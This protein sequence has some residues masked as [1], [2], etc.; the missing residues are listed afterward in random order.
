MTLNAA[1]ALWVKPVA[2]WVNI[3]SDVVDNYNF[4]AGL[5][6]SGATD[7]VARTGQLS[8]VLDNSSS[9]YTPGAVS[10]LSG[11]KSGIPAKLVVTYDGETFIRFY[12]QI[13]SINISAGIY[14]ERTV[15]VT[16]VD[17]MDN[18][19]K[20][21]VSGVNITADQ[22]ADQVITTIKSGMPVKPISSDLDTGINTF[23]QSFDTVTT[24]T[25]ALSEFNKIANSEFGYVYLKK[26]AAHGETLVFD[27]NQAR[28]GMRQLDVLPMGSSE[29]ANLLAEDST[30]LLAEDGEAL[31]VNTPRS[32]IF[33]DGMFS[34]LKVTYGKGLVNRF[35]VKVEPKKEDTTPQILF[36]LQKR[37]KL[38]SGI[39]THVTGAFSDP[40]GGKPITGKN[41]I[42]PVGTTDYT[43]YTNWDGTGSNITGDLTIVATYSA[44]SVTYDLT[45]GNTATGYVWVQA[46]G[47]GVYPDYPVEYEATDGTSIAAY[48]DQSKSINQP[49][50]Q[51]IAPGALEA[52]KIVER[53]KRPHLE[54]SEVSFIANKSDENMQAFLN[55]DIGSLVNISETQTGINGYFYVQSITA[56][57][58]GEGSNS[59]IW[60]TWKLRQQYSLRNG[61]S[62][63]PLVFSAANAYA[64]DWGQIPYLWNVNTRTISVWVNQSSRGTV[65][66]TILAMTSGYAGW[67]LGITT[68]GSVQFV[69]CS[70]VTNGTWVGGFIPL[71]TVTNIVVSRNSANNA[72]NP[73]FY[74]NGVTSSPVVLSTPAG[75][76]A[77][78]G[79]Y[80]TTGN[81]KSAT[82]VLGGGFGGT[83]NDVRIYDSVI[84]ATGITSLYN[85]GIAGT[86]IASLDSVMQ[87]Q[88][89]CIRAEYISDYVTNGI[90]N[91][92][93]LLD[94]CF[95]VVGKVIGTG[96]P[97]LPG[98]VTYT[99]QPTETDGI[100]NYMSDDALGGII[101]N[102]GTATTMY[103]GNS[104]GI[105]VRG[106]L[107]FD[108]TK[109]TNSPPTNASVISATMYLT[110]VVDMST[111]A[112]TLNVYRCLRD[113]G[114]LTST[115]LTWNGTNN[116]SAYGANNT[117]N[118]RES[119]P[120]GSVAVSESLTLNTPVAITLNAAKVQEWI[121][122]ATSNY[123]MV[124]RTDAEGADV[125]QW[126][127]SS[128]AT[129]AYRPK[130]VIIYV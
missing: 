42:T 28:N 9:T 61:L 35:T 2:T 78:D 98:T 91:S 19:A 58:I 48:G 124:I 75:T 76:I 109:G 65:N 13:S 12:G 105:T 81:Y 74:I 60:F 82:F 47:Y 4:S 97:S 107:K 36:S 15:E 18:A 127:S 115:W 92:W 96:L 14:D 50:L 71:G 54:A 16:V 41:M 108:L 46:R 129:A 7:L 106:L 24:T 5:P 40:D 30:S 57:I 110:P 22:T 103:I 100:D 27:N 68:A 85:A 10:A 70:S 118:D 11:W 67:W 95:G 80:L 3:T 34:D 99:T 51:D 102:Y 125:Y 119:T 87:F 59:I 86:Q 123:G 84:G 39:L 113:W 37:A 6:G 49:Y 104:S 120:L 66:N 77:E 1:V 121:N 8:F 126:A 43:M 79:L 114:E 20:Y 56:T 122:G 52:E 29:T 83:I 23:P 88:A 112:R 26:D 128:H 63:I 55:I 64:I 25:K 32:A 45:N 72:N 21:N 53:E 117:T 62:L 33:N 130:L 17:W 90:G 93:N 111:S 31:N 101:T 38:A 89:P 69:Q 116:W 94:N 73:D 44:E